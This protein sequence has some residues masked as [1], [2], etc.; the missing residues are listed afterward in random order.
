[1]DEEKDKANKLPKKPK[2]VKKKNLAQFSKIETSSFSKIR[3]EE[4]PTFA[5]VLQNKLN[6]PISP[7][8]F[9]ENS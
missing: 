4:S 5:P 2:I 9:N 7:P 1:M 6:H 8:S 3:I